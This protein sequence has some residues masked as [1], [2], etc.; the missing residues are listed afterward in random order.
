[1]RGAGS[2]PHIC[3]EVMRRFGVTVMVS[4]A[5]P[6]GVRESEYRRLLATD[7]A[8]QR[9]SWRRMVR[10]AEVYARGSIRHRDHKTIYLDGWH[11]VYMNRE[12]FA[13]HAPQIA[14]LD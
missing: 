1:S 13:R 6:A 5:Y 14:F 12:R 11:R 7:P 4:S 10:D 3:E 2:K 9:M 8:A